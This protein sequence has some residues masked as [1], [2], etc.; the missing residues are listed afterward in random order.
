MIGGPRRGCWWAGRWPGGVAAASGGSP[1]PT[2]RRLVRDQR[3]G[4][5]RGGGADQSGSRRCRSA[6]RSATRGRTRSPP[7]RGA[8]AQQVAQAQQQVTQAEQALAADETWTPTPPLQDHQALTD[9]QNSV[10]SAAATLSADEA[11]Q[12][13]D[14]AGRGASSPACSPGHPEGQPGPATAQ[15]GQ[16]AAGLGPAQRGP[17]S[18]PRPRPRS[19]PTTPR[20]SRPRP[21]WPSSQ[22]TAATSGA[23]YTWL[24][25]G[26]RHHQRGPAGLLTQRPARAAA[27]RLGRRLPGVLRRHGRRRRRGP[28]DPRPDRP[29]LRGRADPEQPLLVGHGGGRAALA[30]R[31]RAAGDRR[32]SCWVRWCSSPGPIRVTSVTP[33]VG[34]GGRRRE[35]AAEAGARSSTPPA[36]RRW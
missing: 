11:K 34:P 24:P 6:G 29:R 1:S 18:A 27:V 14:C 12:A 32:P 36:P 28:A 19:S 20:S 23:T 33:S 22:P 15:P 31:A 7:R 26:G 17:R 5:H 16:P 8:S 10:N 2:G 21:T 9:A 30:D 4:R 13:Q 3:A 25:E 35:W